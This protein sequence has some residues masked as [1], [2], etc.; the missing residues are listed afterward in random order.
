MPAKPSALSSATERHY[1]ELVG[2]IGDDYI[3]YRW[4]RHPVSRSHYAQTYR[5]V[6]FALGRVGTSRHLLEIGSGPGTWTEI[7][8]RHARRVSIVDISS[9]MLGL[10]EKRFPDDGLSLTCGDFLDEDLELPDDVDSI[11][12]GRAL[13]YM[14]DKREMVA[15]SGRH[16]PS[17]GA[18]IVITKNPRW[19]DKRR[20]SPG[21]EALIHSDWIDYQALE[22]HYREAGFVDV[23]TYPVCLGSYFR[24][25]NNAVAAKL[26]DVLQR[27]LYR[28][29]L[30]PRMAW[31]FESYMTVGRKG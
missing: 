11:F 27:G 14:D 25:F 3:E 19:R 18:L 21:G 5:S 28:R 4:M 8:L 20:S 24:P 15:R 17:G 31:L 9:E 12:S 26:C 6:E 30:L 22:E 2:R 29:P 23:T 1:Q 16:L 13:E 7:C 10:V